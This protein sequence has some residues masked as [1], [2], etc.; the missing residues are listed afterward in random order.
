[1]QRKCIEPETGRYSGVVVILT[2]L[3]VKITRMT[4]FPFWLRAIVPYL[5][6]WMDEHGDICKPILT[7]RRAL[8]SL[9]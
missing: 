8:W 5:S 7:V 6:R 1:M 4:V 2:E 9:Y 3:C